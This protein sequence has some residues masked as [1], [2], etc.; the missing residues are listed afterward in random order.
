MLVAMSAKLD[1]EK[2]ARRDRVL[3]AQREFPRVEM[4]TPRQRHF[5]DSLALKWG[6]RIPHGLSK[7]NAS[8]LIDELK[9]GPPGDTARQLGVTVRAQVIDLARPNPTGSMREQHQHGNRF[10]HFSN[11]ELMGMA[12]A[13][14]HVIAPV[15]GLRTE[16]NAELAGRA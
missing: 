8:V 3:D 12:F 11:A 9:S 5:L 15:N 14:R 4:A 7:L 2:A 13:L 10:A 16:L 1:Y 6:L